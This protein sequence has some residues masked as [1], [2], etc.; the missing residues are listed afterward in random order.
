[1]SKKTDKEDDEVPN[2]NNSDNVEDT[3]FYVLGVAAFL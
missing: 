3:I 1:M 2:T